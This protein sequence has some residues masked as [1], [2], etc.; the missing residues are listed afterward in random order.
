MVTLE[1]ELLRLTVDEGSGYII[2]LYDKYA[3]AHHVSVRRPELRLLKEGMGIFTS[4][5]PISVKSLD[6][7]GNVIRIRGDAEGVGVSKE[8]SLN[9]GA[10]NVT[11]TTHGSATSY[12]GGGTARPPYSA[13]RGLT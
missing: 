13:T 4:Y 7:N 1:D 3:N 8:V 2:D 11:I 12:R 9:N 10:V 6:V 5:P